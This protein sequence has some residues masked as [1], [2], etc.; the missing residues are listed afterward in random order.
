[1]C[2][3][4]WVCVHWVLGS[5]SRGF[6][7]SGS[8][9]CG[10]YIINIWITA[11]FVFAKWILPSLLTLSFSLCISH[12][13]C[14]VRSTTEVDWYLLFLIH[15][16]NNR[17]GTPCLYV[18]DLCKIDAIWSPRFSCV[19]IPNLNLVKSDHK[20]LTCYNVICMVTYLDHRATNA[21]P[22]DEVWLLWLVIT[23]LSA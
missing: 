12:V 1:M 2:I 11:L 8:E 3:C 17:P 18:L 14:I 16:R 7:W 20:E 9:K 6:T 5:D 13:W 4:V 21:I 19:V 15:Q 10:N 22:L 23:T